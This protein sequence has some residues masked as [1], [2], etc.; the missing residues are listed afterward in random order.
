[1]I[2]TV[3]R[4]GEISRTLA[5]SKKLR[6]ES[7]HIDFIGSYEEI[8]SCA[9]ILDAKDKEDVFREQMKWTRNTE[10]V[11]EVL[12][13]EE[14]YRMAR[15]DVMHK[16]LLQRLEGPEELQERS[17]HRS[18]VNFM[19]SEGY[20]HGPVRDHIAKLR[21]NLVAFDDLSHEP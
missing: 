7:Y 14:Q 1:M 18:W 15:A 21:P 12:S 9:S 11:R 10:E 13:H 8:Y 5:E 16:R 19:F 17:Q 4:H 3:V 6:G 20:R 2:Q